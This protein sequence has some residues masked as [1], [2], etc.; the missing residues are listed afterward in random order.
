MRKW[1]RGVQVWQKAAKRWLLLLGS[2]TVIIVIGLFLFSPIVQVRDIRVQR[3][4]ARLD[5]ERVK[6]AVAPVFG[7]HLLFLSENDVEALV[8]RAVPDAK[9]V[10]ISKRYPSRLTI[11]VEQQA[12]TARLVLELP[13]EPVQA[14]ASGADLPAPIT[15]PTRFEYL[16]EDGRYVRIPVSASGSELPLI[17]IK[18]ITIPPDSGMPLVSQELLARMQEAE[19]TLTTEF[20]QTIRYR[21]IYLRGRE[22]HLATER[23]SLWFDMTSTL[24][25]QFLRYRTFLASPVVQQARFY[26]DLRLPGAV[27]YK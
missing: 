11:Q 5:I 6:R 18:D 13:K 9:D 19:A 22:Y 7:E 15:E 3:R 23:L 17:T 1:Q 8:R 20:G 21:S 2:S 24:D 4:D 12:L 10:R 14:T 27:V 25:E 16:T 26:V